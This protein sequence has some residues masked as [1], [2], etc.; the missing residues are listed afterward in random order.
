MKAR[1]TNAYTPNMDTPS[2]KRGNRAVFG[3]ILTLLVPPLGLMYLWR[4]G[5]FRMRGR[6]I[7]T[8]IATLE[9]ALIFFLIMPGQQ[10][11]SDA[12][13]PVTPV[14]ATLAPDDGVVTALENID[15]VLAEQ[16]AAEAAEAGVATA[17]PTTDPAVEAAEQEAILNTTVYSVYGSGAK[18]YH[19]Q[20][21]CGT[22]SNRRSLTV[23][24]AMN[25][26]MA[27]CPN[28]DPP[29]YTGSG[30]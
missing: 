23:R 10:L 15:T 8:T 6:M 30:S 2:K 20:E 4:V 28:C 7:I 25:E 29:V 17:E 5:V 12:P 3:L 27:P 14:A 16:Q 13:T 18:Y 21:V 22:Q 24:E 19:S 1:K 9:T 26:G 11:S